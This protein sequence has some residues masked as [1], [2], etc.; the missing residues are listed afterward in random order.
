ML[1]ESILGILEALSGKGKAPEEA[2]CRACKQVYKGKKDCATCS[3][4]IEVKK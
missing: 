4:K 1:R 2:F 3:K